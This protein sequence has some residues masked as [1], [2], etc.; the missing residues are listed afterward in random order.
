MAV[1]VWGS[2]CSVLAVCVVFGS[3]TVWQAEGVFVHL[4]MREVC[5]SVFLWQW[6]TVFVKNQYCLCVACL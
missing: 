6:C 5:E 4:L 1:G 2:L 3:A